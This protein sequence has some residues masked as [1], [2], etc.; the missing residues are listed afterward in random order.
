MGPEHVDREAGFDSEK[1]KDMLRKIEK[2]YGEKKKGVEVKQEKKRETSDEE[3]R[4]KPGPKSKTSHMRRKIDEEGRLPSV[5]KKKEVSEEREG[6][7]RGGR[8]RKTFGSDIYKSAKEELEEML[9][10]KELVNIHDT[11]TNLA[12]TRRATKSIYNKAVGDEEEEE[13]ASSKRSKKGRSSRGAMGEVDEED[14]DEDFRSRRTV[15]FAK[16]RR[17]V[18]RSLASDS[19][20]EENKSFKKIM[21]KKKSKVIESQSDGEKSRRSEKKKKK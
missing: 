18:R 12:G 21:K 20:E 16:D 10:K 1:Y 13:E 8:E 4:P 9:K 17:S 7:R 11:F 6:V 14:D 5:N 15:S 3:I 19:E 2:Q